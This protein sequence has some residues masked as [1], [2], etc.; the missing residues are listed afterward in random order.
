MADL[1]KDSQSKLRVGASVH[2]GSLRATGTV[3]GIDDKPPTKGVSVRLHRPHN[4][5]ET[6]YATHAECAVVERTP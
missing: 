6:C 5:S 2:V 3:T 1:A 4:G